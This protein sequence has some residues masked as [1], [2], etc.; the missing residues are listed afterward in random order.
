LKWMILLT[1]CN[2]VG[3]LVVVNCAFWLAWRKNMIVDR[4]AK[5]KV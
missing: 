3:V 2:G 4:P 1:A 5:F